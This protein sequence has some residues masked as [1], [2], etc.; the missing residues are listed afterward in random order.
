MQ[1]PRSK[2]L[3]ELRAED[4]TLE[5]RIKRA[6]A[7]ARENGHERYTLVELKDNRTLILETSNAD[8]PAVKS[9]LSGSKE[10][11]P[12]KRGSSLLM[13]LVKIFAPI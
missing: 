8:K 9:V 7:K 13:A 3:D 11:T 5:R 2:T 4:P 6:F 12:K 1:A 10:Q